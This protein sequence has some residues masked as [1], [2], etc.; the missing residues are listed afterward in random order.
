MLLLHLPR[1]NSKDYI[2]TDPE[3]FVSTRQSWKDSGLKIMANIDNKVFD[4][5]SSFVRSNFIFRNF[6]NSLQEN[7]VEDSSFI[8]LVYS[9]DS[10]VLTNANFVSALTSIHR[11]DDD[12]ITN[13]RFSDALIV[14]NSDFLK[15]AE[16]GG[17][18]SRLNTSLLERRDSGFS[19]S[20]QLRAEYISA[21][22]DSFNYEIL[23]DSSLNDFVNSIDVGL[24]RDS[25]FAEF[26]STTE[27]FILTDEDFTGTLSKLDNLVLSN[28]KF[29]ENVQILNEEVKATS[30]F[31][32]VLSQTTATELSRRGEDYETIAELNPSETV[33]ASN[34]ATISIE[35]TDLIA[36]GISERNI[37]DADFAELITGGIVRV[38]DGSGRRPATERNDVERLVGIQERRNPTITPDSQT[39]IIIH[40]YTGNPDGENIALLE[41]AILRQ[42]GSNDRVLTLD[43]HEPAAAQDL[44]I[45]NFISTTWAAPVAEYVVRTLER[46]Y[47]ITPEDASN[48]VNLIGHSLGVY[49]EA[50]IGEAYRDGFDA[51]AGNPA[52][53]GNGVGVRTLT[54]L[55]PG[56]SSNNLLGV[57]LRTFE[58]IQ[59][60]LDGRKDGVQAPEA[61]RDV[62]RFSRS[63]NGLESIMGNEAYAATADEAIAMNFSSERITLGTEL[64]LDEHPRVVK[65]F[66]KL[67]DE[68][69]RVGK[70]LGIG[71]YQND[72][73]TLALTNWQELPNLPLNGADGSSDQSY[74][75]LLSVDP[76]DEIA[77]LIGA[78][79]SNIENNIFLSGELST[80][81]GDASLTYGLTTTDPEAF[82]FAGQGD[83]TLYG[84]GGEDVLLGGRGEDILNG[85]TGADILLGGADRDIFV[86]APGDGSV[87][88]DSTNVIRDFIVGEDEFGL[89]AGL[90]F[91]DLIITG[92]Q[93]PTG[94]ST[95]I[96]ERATGLFLAEVQGVKSTDLIEGDFIDRFQADPFGLA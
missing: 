75:A 18:L 58:A 25:S 28:G 78:N 36:S 14:M 82:R 11:R 44:G 77:G 74:T 13:G 33:I 24:F 67:G 17:F 19:F 61:F 49:V 32:E 2:A 43:W 63:Y 89:V 12:I 80:T 45:G 86:L 42:A 7:K 65:A 3:L 1:E 56:S 6:I 92:G 47:G 70:N 73:Q 35:K 59:Y 34:G 83:D 87:N 22:A 53:S 26:I 88:I 21:L 76:N 79:E 66:A 64:G 15:S 69:G 60:D 94:I 9:L 71:A 55:D 37:Y 27:A 57:D 85:G 8:D 54:A 51:Y 23:Q 10:S 93:R 81:I 46:E 52:F 96:R 31:E 62:S 95:F 20:G 68:P 4:N 38:S 5:L 30:L 39:W 40:G 90:E 48:T 29:T 84:E 50:A 41:E 16:F 91:E 72:L